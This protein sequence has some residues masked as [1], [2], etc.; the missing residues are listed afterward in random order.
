MS[1]EEEQDWMKEILAGQQQMKKILAKKKE[2]SPEKLE[3][4]VGVPSRKKAKL[5]KEKP[6]VQ[7]DSVETAAK[8]LTV[9]FLRK[10]ESLS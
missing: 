8:K 7:L 4:A 1:D 9:F 10:Q 5:E 3:S 6:K 2:L